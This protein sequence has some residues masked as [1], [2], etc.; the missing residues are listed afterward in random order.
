[1]PPATSSGAYRQRAEPQDRRRAQ[2]VPALV[3]VRNRVGA[4]ERDRG[5]RDYQ[6]GGDHG[7]TS[8]TRR[9]ASALPVAATTAASTANVGATTRAPARSGAR[10][11]RQRTVARAAHKEHLGGVRGGVDQPPSASPAAGPAVSGSEAHANRTNHSV[12]G[13]IGLRR[14]RERSVYYG[15][16][17]RRPRSSAARSGGRHCDRKPSAHRSEGGS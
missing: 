9:A 5:Q 14:L 2:R 8:A 6:D 12:I 7:A 11:T 16:H 10:A 1:M 13:A 15:P 3:A 4:G 17:G